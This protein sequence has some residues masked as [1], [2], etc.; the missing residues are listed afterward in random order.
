MQILDRAGKVFRQWANRRHA[1]RAVEMVIPNEDAEQL[2]LMEFKLD[3][4]TWQAHFGSKRGEESVV[5]KL[6]LGIGEY[7]AQYGG[8]NYLEFSMYHPSHGPLTVTIQRAKGKTPAQLKTEAEHERDHWKQQYVL[9]LAE[10]TAF[11]DGER[12]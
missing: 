1:Q 10:H 2:R 5:A 6:V 7:F 12:P 3:S 9:L 8:Q 11:Q 4:N